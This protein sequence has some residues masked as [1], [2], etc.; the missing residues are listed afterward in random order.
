ME[1]I[2]L[3]QRLVT[4]TVGVGLP[5]RHGGQLLIFD[6]KQRHLDTTARTAVS[7]IEYVSGQTSHGHLRLFV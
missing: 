4:A 2:A 1:A 3:E 5:H 7:S 6:A